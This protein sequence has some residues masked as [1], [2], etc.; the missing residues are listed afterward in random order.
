MIYNKAQFN[1]T[2]TC[3]TTTTTA[4]ATTTNSL[5][6]QRLLNFMIL[7]QFGTLLDMKCPI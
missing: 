5:K 3:I 1:M 7:F 4:T 6:V 2:T